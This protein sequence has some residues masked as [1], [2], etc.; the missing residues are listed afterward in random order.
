MSSLPT[1]STPLHTLLSVEDLAI[2]IH[3]PTRSALF[4]S[5]SF[6][7]PAGLSLG[8]VGESGSGKTSILRAILRMLPTSMQQA[9]GKIQ[10]YEKPNQPVDIAAYTEKACAQ[11]RK[12]NIA[13]IW[14]NPQATLHPVQSIEQQLLSALPDPLRRQGKKARQE[15]VIDALEQVKLPHPTALLKKIPAELSGGQCQRISL[16]QALLRKPRLLLADEPTSALDSIS[17]MEFIDVVNQ[18]AKRHHMGVLLFSHDLAA[19]RSMCFAVGILHR[20]TLAEMV[21]SQDWPNTQLPVAAQF[22]RAHAAV[23]IQETPMAEAPAQQ[24]IQQANPKKPTWQE[25]DLVSIK[26]LSVVYRRQRWLPWQMMPT[27]HALDDVSLSLRK[28]ETLAIVGA[29]GSGKTTLARALVGLVAPKD[30]AVKIDGYVVHPHSKETTSRARLLAHVVWQNAFLSINPLLTAVEAVMEPLTIHDPQMGID[31][32][33]R[34]AMLTLDRMGVSDLETQRSMLALS[35]GQQ[36]RVGLA[37]ALVLTPKV[38]ILDEPFS[39]VDAPKRSYLL[40]FL[41][42]VQRDFQL[43]MILI[44]HDLGVVQNIA[45]SVAVLDHGKLVEWSYTNDL[46]NN[47]QSEVTRKLID[48]ARV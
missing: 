13:V 43:S 37:R 2:E 32:K 18:I 5:V 48:A 44:S 3:Q 46:F 24:E 11:W 6:A 39:S 10:F 1:A 9:K 47:P 35:G 29:S 40:N 19:V 38:L 45:H 21:T 33:R 22:W 41:K 7:V 28:G 25:E 14:Q 30:G 20:G 23:S 31:E 15:A 36:Q 34:K 26:R 42:D 16:A 8:I 4:S 27:Y 17:Q 12:K